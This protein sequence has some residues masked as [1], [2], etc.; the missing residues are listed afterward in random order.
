MVN[1]TMTDHQSKP[2]LILG[3]KKPFSSMDAEPEIMIKQ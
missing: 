2:I 1:Q 3:F